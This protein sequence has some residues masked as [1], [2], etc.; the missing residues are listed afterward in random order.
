MSRCVTHHACD[1]TLERI[2]RLET[3]LRF[4]RRILEDIAD[5]ADDVDYCEVYRRIDAVLPEPST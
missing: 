3:A 5:G 1:C 2:A 4:A